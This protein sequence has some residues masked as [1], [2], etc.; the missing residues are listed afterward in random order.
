MDLS[1][2]AQEIEREQ[3]SRA[4]YRIDGWEKYWPWDN[5]PKWLAKKYKPWIFGDEDYETNK[6]NDRE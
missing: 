3:S 6:T 5:M 4:F 1:I 2:E